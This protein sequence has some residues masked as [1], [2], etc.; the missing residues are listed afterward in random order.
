ME[1]IA[2]QG[3]TPMNTATAVSEMCLASIKV[4]GL[5]KGF[6]QVTKSI[7][8]NRSKL[9]IVAKSI[10][11]KDM[12][13]VLSGLAAQYNVPIVKV[14]SHEEL[15]EYTRICKVDEAGNIVKKSKCAVVSIENFG[16]PTEG[17]KYVLS[18]IA[19]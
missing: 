18:S 7:I 14:D 19:A 15:A 4:G 2:Q 6:R 5:I 9:L 13:A 16:K 12:N 11:E 3:E 1:T 17:Q 8:G 10:N